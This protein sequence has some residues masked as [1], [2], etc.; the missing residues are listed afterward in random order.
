[1][2]TPLLST[3][4]VLSVA[5]ATHSH[6]D[7]QTTPST[8]V[9]TTNHAEIKGLIKTAHTPEEY[10]ALAEYY[11]QQESKFQAKADSERLEWDRR[12]QVTTHA[13]CKCPSPVD[14]AHNM[15]DY[16]VNK[17]NKMGAKAAEYQKKSETQQPTGS[18]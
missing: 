18:V 1:M 4:L 12:V 16:Y 7:A 14:T 8:L 2:N 15:Y 13:V 10:H 3:V 5:L 11:R 17:A 9:T 6:L